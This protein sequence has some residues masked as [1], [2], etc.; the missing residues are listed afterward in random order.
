MLNEN[1]IVEEQPC[2]NRNE[3]QQDVYEVYAH[4]FKT[5]ADPEGL[6]RVMRIAK[7]RPNESLRDDTLVS[8]FAFPYQWVLAG[9]ARQKQVSNGEC[10]LSDFLVSIGAGEYGSEGYEGEVNKLDGIFYMTDWTSFKRPSIERDGTMLTYESGL[11]ALKLNLTHIFKENGIPTAGSQTKFPFTGGTV[12]PVYVN[13]TFNALATQN[14]AY[15]E[16]KVSFQAKY[17]GMTVKSKA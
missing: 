4:M 7:L 3:Y 12:Q 2:Q 1:M 17:P 5:K 13:D 16:W 15:T 14:A 8:Y 11:R 9:T 6:T 10:N